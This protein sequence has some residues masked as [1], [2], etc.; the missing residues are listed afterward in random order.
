MGMANILKS[1]INSMIKQ[2]S[3]ETNYAAL[4]WRENEVRKRNQKMHS[5]NA[6]VLNVRDSLA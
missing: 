4:T 6:R 1:K 3:L 2:L 5:E